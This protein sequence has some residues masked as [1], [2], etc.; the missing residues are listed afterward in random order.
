MEGLEERSWE[1]WLGSGVWM[2]C[3]VDL[4]A[5]RGLFLAN[6]PEKGKERRKR[7]Y[8][9]RKKEVRRLA[10]ESK[11]RVDE[12]FGRKLSEKYNENKKLFW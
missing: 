10:K 7:E 5:K 1:G 4:C 11:E 3:L 2:E 8:K 6:V 9:A 12:E